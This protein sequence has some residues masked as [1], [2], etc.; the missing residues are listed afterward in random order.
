M[1]SALWTRSTLLVLLAALLGIAGCSSFDRDADK[2]P[3]ELTKFKAER[4]L[5]KVW[6]RSVGDGQGG[7]YHRL[8][9]ALDGDLIVAAS[10]NGQVRAYDAERGK[11]RWRV[12]LGESLI[13]GVGLADERVFLGSGN[14][15]IIALSAEDG[16]QLW[17]HDL[18]GEVLAPPQSDGERVYVQTFDGRVIAL[19]AET[20]ERLWSHASGVPVL[21]LRG[22]STPLLYSDLVI[23]GLASGKLVAL[24]RETGG[25][26]WEQRIAL[27]QGSTEIERLVD[28]DGE[29]LLHN[30][31]LY[32][33][34]YQGQLAALDPDSGRRLW[35]REVSSHVGLAAGFS[36]IYV[37]GHAG[38]VTAFGINGQGVRWE[39]TVLARRQLT[40]PTS[41]AS[42]VAVGDFE[43][44]LH[45][46]SQVDGHLVARVRVN[47]SGLRAPLLLSGD[48]L[49]VYANNGALVAYR[50]VQER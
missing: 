3:A 7:L 13:G 29:L 15:S 43:G 37:V 9:P 35:S 48:L 11:P 22:T 8:V 17:T 1:R 6:S 46:L 41:W 24:D 19:N 39:Q 12:R 20:G 50:L 14:G 5:K 47:S 23:V 49:Y 40:A 32:A 36:N 21:T 18:S 26:R 28:V 31:T 30:G 25:L 4:K 33:V 44:Y 10:H 42:Y 34:A 27:P 38:S 16:R 45:L 2:K